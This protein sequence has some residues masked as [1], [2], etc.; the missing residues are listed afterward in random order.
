MHFNTA[1]NESNNFDVEAV[2]K[3]GSALNQFDYPSNIFDIVMA[4]GVFQHIENDK[5]VFSLMKKYLAKNGLMIISLRN[6]LFAFSTFNNP[7]YEFYK[8][9][10]KEFLASEDK[11]ILDTF[12]KDVFDLSQPPKRKGKVI[13]PGIDDLIY[14]YHNPF[15]IHELLNQVGLKVVDMDFY[16]YHATPPLLSKYTPKIFN[17]ISLQL[18]DQ[19]N[20]WRSRFLC[21]TYIL[22]C[23]HS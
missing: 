20:D 6:P 2:F 16:R 11:D 19:K 8:E 13:N 9:L 4:L 5:D 10:F 12:L 21:S 17:K 1:K 15:T 22:Y 3:V 18:D 14:K 23:T 7:S